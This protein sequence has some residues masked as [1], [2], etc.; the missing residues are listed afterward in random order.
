MMIR[1]RKPLRL[2]I[3]VYQPY[4]Q[5]ELTHLWRQVRC[6]LEFTQMCDYG[7]NLVDHPI[8]RSYSITFD[9]IHPLFTRS[10][11]YFHFWVLRLKTEFIGLILLFGFSYGVLFG[12]CSMWM[13][14]LE[15][16]LS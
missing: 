8:T 5:L 11:L 7:K 10:P 13:V 2:I 12:Q 16:W 14:S 3:D 6:I 4:D 1:F 9:H 15:W